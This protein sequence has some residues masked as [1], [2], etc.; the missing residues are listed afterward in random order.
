MGSG[1]DYSSFI[2]HVGVPSLNIGFGGENEGGEYHSIYDSYDH[3]SKYKDPGFAY[4]VTLAQT[5]GRAALRLSEADA[6]PFDFTA[7]HKTVKGYINELMNNVEQMREKAKVEN[8]NEEEFETI[9]I[10]LL[11]WR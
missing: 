3:Y 2:Q 4:G 6:L 9:E 11:L 1:S 10:V 8:E 5:A 7:L